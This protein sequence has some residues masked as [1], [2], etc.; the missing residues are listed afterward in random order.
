MEKVYL[1]WT[2]IGNIFEAHHD[3]STEYIRVDKVDNMLLEQ[4]KVCSKEVYNKSV[5]LGV[6]IKHSKL[7]KDACLNAGVDNDK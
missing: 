5:I 2:D 3:K 4:R 7:I 6:T 1:M